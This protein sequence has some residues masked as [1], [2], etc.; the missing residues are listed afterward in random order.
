M[1]DDGRRTKGRRRMRGRGC[2][3][4]GRMLKQAQAGDDE[5]VG[6][7]LVRRQCAVAKDPQ[8]MFCIRIDGSTYTL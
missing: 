4:T 3:A 1:M 6:L 8:T 7:W 2:T 5:T